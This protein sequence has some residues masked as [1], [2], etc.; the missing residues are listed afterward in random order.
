MEKCMDNAWNVFMHSNS[1]K[2][3]MHGKPLDN[4]WQISMHSN[5]AWIMPGN[6]ITRK[7][8]G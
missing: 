6:C 2:I 4:A 1:V 3:A 5:H 8:H 7:T